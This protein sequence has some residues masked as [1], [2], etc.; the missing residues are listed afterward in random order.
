[1]LHYFNS[2]FSGSTFGFN[3]IFLILQNLREILYI[4]SEGGGVIIALK[5]K[6][7]IQLLESLLR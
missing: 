2:D 6:Y 5:R 1:M 7:S 4:G 3:F